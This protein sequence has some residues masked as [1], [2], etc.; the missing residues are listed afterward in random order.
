MSFSPDSS[1]CAGRWSSTDVAQIT[2]LLYD[3]ILKLR[4]LADS[5]VEELK[6]QPKR[7]ISDLR[8][9]LPHC[10][11]ESVCELSSRIQTQASGVVITQVFFPFIWVGVVGFGCMAAPPSN[12]HPSPRHTAVSRRLILLKAAFRFF[13]CLSYYFFSQ[14]QKQ[15]LMIVHMYLYSKPVTMETC[16]VWD[17]VIKKRVK[18]ST[19]TVT[20]CPCNVTV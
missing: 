9:Q 7:N 18:R 16:I 19:H 11:R 13:F 12:H 20:L 10:Q 1:A 17:F 5:T 2:F 8:Q 4:R 15:Y 6:F 3:L 14:G